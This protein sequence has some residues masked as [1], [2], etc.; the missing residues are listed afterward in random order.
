[1]RVFGSISKLFSIL[2]TEDGYDVTLEPDANTTYTANRTITLPPGDANKTLVSTSGAQNISTT[3]TIEAASVT[4]T[5]YMLIQGIT[6]AQRNSLTPSV[7]T[8]VYNTT[9]GGLEEYTASGW[10][11]VLAGTISNADVASN[12]A[13]DGTKINPNFGT[14]PVQTSSDVTARSVAVVGTGTTGRLTLY[15]QTGDVPTYGS[16]LCLYAKNDNKLYIKFPD[17]S[18]SAV[19][20]AATNNILPSYTTT[21]RDALTPSAGM[22]IYNS[23]DNRFQ[24][25]VTGTGW[26]NLHGW[27]S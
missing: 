15:L 13:I 1:M 21:Q 14:Q 11:T 20:T 8:L 9:V 3:G 18:V 4:S 10:K 22:V 6:T 25:Y 5:S 2:F 16:G 19:L 27:G 7:G 17:G 12:A 23:T 24:G 26:V